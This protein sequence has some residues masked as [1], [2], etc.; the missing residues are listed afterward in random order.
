MAA[1]KTTSPPP[2]VKPGEAVRGRNG[3]AN[4]GAIRTKPGRADS[5][6]TVSFSCSDK[7]ATWNVL[8]LQGALLEEVVEPVYLSGIVVGGVGEMPEGIN[9]GVRETW[10]DTIQS[11]A[12]RALYGRV[13]DVEGMLDL[14]LIYRKHVCSSTLKGQG[15]LPSPYRLNK[16]IIHLSPVP[17]HLSKPIVQTR[18]PIDPAPSGLA[19]LHTTPW[20][21][22]AEV[23]HQGCNRGGV[24]KKP[25][26]SLLTEKS[27]SRGSK[28]E[29]FQA[30]SRLRDLLHDK[31]GDRWS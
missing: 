26:M 21:G 22:Q 3:Y 15:K 23:L 29:V 9:L 19:I 27:R 18:T 1:L 28:F 11:E 8:G 10:S 2:L 5:F 14:S 6:P 30:F 13:S 12:E 7:I 4:Y 16:P 25:G 31:D 17:F 24:W 20:V